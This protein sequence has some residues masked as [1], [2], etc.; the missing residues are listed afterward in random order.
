MIATSTRGYESGMSVFWSVA[1]GWLQGQESRV[2]NNVNNVP[3][4]SHGGT[5]LVKPVVDA[6]RCAS[7]ANHGG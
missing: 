5:T 7:Q 6:V 3:Y 4:T 2:Q 1:K